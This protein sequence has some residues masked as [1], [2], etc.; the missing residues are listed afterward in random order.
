[1]ALDSIIL[2]VWL[3]H[4][5]MFYHCLE[6]HVWI[7]YSVFSIIGGFKEINKYINKWP[8]CAP[9]CIFKT[10]RTQI[11]GQIH[12]YRHITLSV[13]NHKYLLLTICLFSYWCCIR[14]YIAGKFGL[15]PE[16][17]DEES[18]GCTFLVQLKFIKAVKSASGGQPI[19]LVFWCN[20]HIQ[21]WKM[22]TSVVIG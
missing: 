1:M 8:L 5:F 10:Q 19:Y 6:M 9:V 16:V 7:L 18:D 17:S 13:M 21:S 14:R 2:C 11:V 12:C 3:F 22:T 20:D 4:V 15:C